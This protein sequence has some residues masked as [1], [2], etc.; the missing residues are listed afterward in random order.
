MRRSPTRSPPL[1][2]APIVIDAFSRGPSWGALGRRRE[3]RRGSPRHPRR[4][5]ALV[6]AD[7][8]L[9]SRP[10]R[11]LNPSPPAPPG[12]R[13]RGRGAPPTAAV[14]E[15]RR[16][17]WGWRAPGRRFVG[18]PRRAAFAAPV[19]GAP[20]RRHPL[21]RGGPSRQA[22]RRRG[23]TS[24]LRRSTRSA[25]GASRTCAGHRLLD[26]PRSGPAAEAL[27]NRKVRRPRPAEHRGHR[28]ERVPPSGACPARGPR[29]ERVRALADEGPA[30]EGAAPAAKRVRRDALAAKQVG[31]LR[32]DPGAGA[33]KGL[34]P[35]GESR[36][37]GFANGFRHH[38]GG[39]LGRRSRRGGAPRC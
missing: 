11:E 15:A 32:R 10:W 22:P 6:R 28:D 18:A 7:D 4:M 16:C 35:R 20:A 27:K 19:R 33:T 37:D 39:H 3:E 9:G 29:E 5:R 34:E 14:G 12:R 38:G 8:A 26:D 1:P 2:P 13:T 36:I 21:R 17:R 23:Q 30:A 25:A 24:G 31:R